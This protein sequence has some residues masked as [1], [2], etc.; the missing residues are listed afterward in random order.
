MGWVCT[1]PSVV[2]ALPRLFSWFLSLAVISEGP[3]VPQSRAVSWFHGFTLSQISPGRLNWWVTVDPSC[4]RLLPLATTGDGNCLLHAASLGK[5]WLNPPGKQPTSP[6]ERPHH[7]SLGAETTRYSGGKA[8][9]CCCSSWLRVELV[10]KGKWQRSGSVDVG[11]IEG[12]GLPA[13]A[14]A[15][16]IFLTLCLGKFPLDF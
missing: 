10:C 11:W 13:E 16:Q 3:R 1:F 4:Q 12:M 15:S 2:Q 14:D 8:G 6:W 7:P 5:A 9:W